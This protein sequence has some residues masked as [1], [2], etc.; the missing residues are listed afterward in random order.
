MIF[1]VSSFIYKDFLNLRH[2]DGFDFNPSKA[3]KE[4]I[5][6]ESKTEIEFLTVYQPKFSILSHFQEMARKS[7]FGRL[8]DLAE[9]VIKAGKQAGKEA[10]AEIR[11]LLGMF[12]H[13][14]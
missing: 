2:V 4:K 8:G 3:T 9:K 13:F 10:V 14:F 11:N 5:I 1:K 6:N 7:F 12:I